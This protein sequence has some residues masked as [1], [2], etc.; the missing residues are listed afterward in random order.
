MDK[1]DRKDGR[2][3]FL[4]EMKNSINRIQF[5]SLIF[6]EDHREREKR[7]NPEFK[8]W[9]QAVGFRSNRF[10]A[11]LYGGITNREG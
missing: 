5:L 8:R 2:W 9:K 4:E 6:K 11:I 3:L 10:K 7:K 1:W